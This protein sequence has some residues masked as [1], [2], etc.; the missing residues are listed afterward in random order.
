MFHRKRK[1][2]KKEVMKGAEKLTG[3]SLKG[4]MH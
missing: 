4:R 1:N 2:L 3:A